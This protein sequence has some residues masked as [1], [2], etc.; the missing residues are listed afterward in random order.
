QVARL[1]QD[2][3]EDVGGRQSYLAGGD[4]VFRLDAVLHDVPVTAKIAADLFEKEAKV[5]LVPRRSG[6]HGWLTRAVPAPPP[7]GL[8]EGSAS[9][10]FTIAGSARI[11]ASFSRSRPAEWISSSG[12]FRRA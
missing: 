1:D 10:A 12:A 3:G 5:A 9:G 6:F 2:I 8:R 11:S 4:D 7:M